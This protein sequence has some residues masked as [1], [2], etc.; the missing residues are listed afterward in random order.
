M[1]RHLF[2]GTILL[3]AALPSQAGV[4]FSNLVQPGNQY[5][6]DGVGIGHTP[7]FPNPG[8]Y[9]LYGVHFIPS[10][11]AQ[12]TII[13][14]PLSVLS[15]PNQIQ[16]FLMSDAGGSPGS[17][18][19]SFPLS[20]LPVPPGP[21]PL[22]TI[23]SLLDP[24]LLG[25]T[26]YWF[27][28]TGG[29]STFATWTLNLFQGDGN[30]GGAVQSVVGGITQPW[31]TGSGTRT[32]ALQVSGTPVPEPSITAL[33]GCALLFLMIRRVRAHCTIGRGLTS[34]LSC[35]MSNCSR[36]PKQNNSGASVTA[37]SR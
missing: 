37:R 27:V 29:P 17:I 10:T 9:L 11:T 31:I 36:S 8:D 20:N 2:W 4:I 26:Q 18:L 15:G 28:A 16:A 35:A 3:F 7:G 30:D 13:Q 24:L 12:L 23:Q 1:T 33:S 34:A 6:P 5:G 14:A 21:F 25:G 19:E 22:V 32:G